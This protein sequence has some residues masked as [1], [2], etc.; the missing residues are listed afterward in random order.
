MAHPGSVSRAMPHIATRTA[1]QPAA[2]TRSLNT[3]AAMSG[4]RTT[5]VPVRN[6]DNV[7][8]TSRRPV[9]CSRK[10]AERKRRAAL[11]GSRPW[12]SSLE[13]GS[14]PPGQARPLRSR[15]ARSE[16]R[17]PTFPSTFHWSPRRPI[18]RRQWRQSAAGPEPEKTASS[19][20]WDDELGSRHDAPPQR[21][22]YVA[23]CRQL[24][25]GVSGARNLSANGT[26]L[27][28]QLLSPSSIVTG[29]EACGQ[30]LRSPA[31]LR[32]RP[33]RSP[34]CSGR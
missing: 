24:R 33:R 10:P 26:A 32:S 4:V 34:L 31:A 27:Q 28:S 8:E 25:S 22:P 20:A 21:R 2:P 3:T 11:R 7:A 19:P 18:P 16:T 30:G 15:T 13:S 23:A 1:T 14:T 9:V 17:L 29:V 6:P 5:I 12:R